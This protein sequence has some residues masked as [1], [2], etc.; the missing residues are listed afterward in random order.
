MA[1]TP[2]AHHGGLEN[3]SWIEDAI[4]QVFSCSKMQCIEKRLITK[5][6][7]CEIDEAL[8]HQVYAA[9]EYPSAA[10]YTECVLH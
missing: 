10:E 8:S 2:T 3:S 5:Y 7:R 9:T 6:V 1:A 4:P